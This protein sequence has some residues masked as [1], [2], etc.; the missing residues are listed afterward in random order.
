[1]SKCPGRKPWLILRLACTFHNLFLLVNVCHVSGYLSSVS[2]VQHLQIS[3]PSL[4][5]P[6]SQDP[7]SL[8]LPHPS[9]PPSTLSAG[10]S[11]FYF[12]PRPIGCLL[13]GRRCFYRDIGESLYKG[14]L[15][16][17]HS[18]ASDFGTWRKKGRFKTPGALGP[19]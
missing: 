13:I 9:F 19:L 16:T 5:L 4:L 2:C 11:P 12:L 8:P 14:V 6:Q 1:M 18:Q 10:G 3:G 15:S 17:P 7:P